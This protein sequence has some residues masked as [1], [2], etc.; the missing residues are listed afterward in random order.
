MQCSSASSSAEHSG[1]NE[2]KNKVE[3]IQNKI[4]VCSRKKKTKNTGD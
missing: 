4:L 1:Y 2:K 3:E